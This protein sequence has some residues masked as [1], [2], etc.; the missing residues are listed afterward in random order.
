MVTVAQMAGTGTRMVIAVARTSAAEGRHLRRAAG[1]SGMVVEEAFT[2]M[3]TTKA[4]ML[5]PDNVVMIQ[6][7]PVRET[8][9][10]R[11]RFP[12]SRRTSSSASSPTTSRSPGY[13]RR[14]SFHT[15]VLSPPKSKSC[16]NVTRSSTTYAVKLLPT[17]FPSTASMT[18]E[19]N[20]GRVLP[21]GSST[22]HNS[23]SR[24]IELQASIHG[25][26]L[27]VGYFQSVRPTV[28]RLLVNVDQALAAFYASGPLIDVSKKVLGQADVS[29]RASADRALL[30]R[31]F[32]K[33]KVNVPALA[34]AKSTRQHIRQIHD[35]VP[36]AG[37]LTFDL[38]GKLTSVKDYFAQTHSIT[39]IHPDYFG[40]VVSPRNSKMQ[41]V[42]PAE[43]CVVCED[44]FYQRRL[45]EA[46]TTKALE[47]S[48][49]KPYERQQY[50]CGMDYRDKKMDLQTPL[51][52]YKESPYILEAGMTISS[53][54]AE[55]EGKQ[56]AP[57][58][59]LFN[60]RQE[61]PRNGSWNFN[62]KQ[63]HKPARIDHFIFINFA[64]V[65]RGFDQEDFPKVSSGIQRACSDIGIGEYTR[66]YSGNMANVESI[67]E[68][69]FAD[70]PLDKIMDNVSPE[71]RKKAP[72]PKPEDHDVDVKGDP[73]FNFSRY[74]E[75]CLTQHP[76]QI[77]AL[78]R[79]RTIF[80]VLLPENAQPQYDAI[81]HWGDIVRGVTTQCICM[82]GVR[83]WYPNRSM[84][85]RFA[86]NVAIKIN[87]RLGGINW[88]PNPIALTSFDSGFPLI[89]GADVG[90]PGPNQ[91]RPSI[92]SV[93]FSRDK[94]AMQY[95]ALT[96]AQ[97]PRLEMVEQL[98]GKVL[99]ALRQFLA[100]N[101][102]NVA[103]KGVQIVPTS[104][105]FYRDGLSEGQFEVFARQEI[106]EVEQ[107]ISDAW[108][109]P[110]PQDQ[111][112]K[113]LQLPPSTLTSLCVPRPP[114]TYIVVTKRHHVRF[115]ATEDGQKVDLRNG[116]LRAGFAT[117]SGIDNPYYHDFYLQSHHALQ[118]TA[119][120]AHYTVLQDRI[121]DNSA[122]REAHADRLDLIRGMS[123][124]LCHAYSRATTSVSIPAPVYYADA[125]ILHLSW[126]AHAN[127]VQQIACRRG[128]IHLDVSLR[129]GGDPF[130][131]D[132]SDIS[133]AAIE[134][135]IQNWCQSFRRIFNGHS[136]MYFI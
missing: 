45:T 81:K 99:T 73:I 126:Q 94:D 131:D 63:T 54:M 106:A 134:L 127:D 31:H 30:S 1:V 5:Q 75:R 113:E 119:R 76:A 58:T 100:H 14:S 112:S 93:V 47:L 135:K 116:N 51:S 123:F 133:E 72:A 65:E 132:S 92:A 27:R 71:D 130:S 43:L 37:Y 29:G 79:H 95:D 2:T 86:K 60:G 3:A 68:T 105:V 101:N 97:P 40:V 8:T 102:P 88:Q 122:Q 17:S 23:R 70:I 9:I 84:N 18:E 115:F 111:Q 46:L 4:I 136:P 108:S 118:G 117:T 89:I 87:V 90:H 69:A 74:R 103:S 104:V 77:F 19:P 124:Y 67:L 107:G 16:T 24:E 20:F 96:F 35:I 7:R 66:E 110:L 78:A 22:G 48:K 56:L 83:K 109:M 52:S 6:E 26:A 34:R 128:N 85:D 91:L 15:M 32:R 21:S 28:G 39:L 125:R 33:V 59:L 82:S 129:Y 121:L 49:K 11:E 10:A 62:S 42:I 25:I 114:L 53:Q 13:R 38:N 55:V 36:K 57:P 98:R 120:P 44:Q 80:L 50:I 61:A 64:R 41:V 12:L